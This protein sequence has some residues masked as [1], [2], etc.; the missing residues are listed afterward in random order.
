MSNLMDRSL[1]WCCLALEALFTSGC[2]HADGDRMLSDRERKPDWQIV[3]DRDSDLPSIAAFRRG[4]PGPVWVYIEGDGKAFL[5]RTA[6]A[7]DPTP[8]APVALAL[9]SL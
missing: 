7:T 1:S 2:Q 6:L 5:T 8:A 3:R 4:A 9:A